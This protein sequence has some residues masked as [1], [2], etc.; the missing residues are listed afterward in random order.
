MKTT[1]AG[2]ARSA[3][4]PCR[5]AAKMGRYCLETH[6]PERERAGLPLDREPYAGEA[7]AAPNAP[8][9][10]T[11]TGQAAARVPDVASPAAHQATVELARRLGAPILTTDPRIYEG[12]GVQ[13]IA[14]PAAPS[15]EAEAKLAGGAPGAP[16]VDFERLERLAAE[17]LGPMP[18]APPADGAPPPPPPAPPPE[19][20]P[21]RSL[22]A[23][24]FDADGC[25]EWLEMGDL[26]IAHQLRWEPTPGAQ[27]KKGGAQLAR[28]LNYYM[29]SKADALTH[30]AAG[31]LMWVLLT[32]SPRTLGLFLAGPAK[33]AAPAAAPAAPPPPTATGSPQPAPAD[34]GGRWSLAGLGAT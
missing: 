5:L 15:A 19:T 25:A 7:C 30:P 2:W 6:G 18:A 16:A 28:L 9:G 3:A 26:A 10:P 33:S 29:P 32:Y 13:A 14:F 8:P 31:M 11:A 34:N 24:P 23:G 17:K 22:E 1:C 21:A 12:E 4:R 27:L 20:A